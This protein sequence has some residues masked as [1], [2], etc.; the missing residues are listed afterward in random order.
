[1][2]T[3]NVP[4]TLWGEAILTVA[5]LINRMPTQVLGYKTALEVFQSVYPTNHVINY[6]PL[7][8]FGCTSFIHIH[9]HN[10]RKFDP[11]T[12]NCVFLGYSPTKKGYKCFDP[13]TKKMFVSM[14]I[15]FFE[16][17]PYLTKNS[18]QGESV[19]IEE[20]FLNFWETFPTLESSN[21]TRLV[22]SYPAPS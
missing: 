9:S 21:S 22:N 6:L 10:R 7:R 18:L 14:D 20:S 19:T 8:I 17:Q 2:L 12:I 1:M 4:K 11:R 3:T 16:N 5:F 15:S 13:Q